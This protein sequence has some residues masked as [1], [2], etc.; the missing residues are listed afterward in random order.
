MLPSPIGWRLCN[1]AS[2]LTTI[3]PEPSFPPGKGIRE[4]T[5]P[6][7]SRR[8]YDLNSANVTHALSD[9]ESSLQ[10]EIPGA[11]LTEAGMYGFTRT[12]PAYR[13]RAAVVPVLV[14]EI[15]PGK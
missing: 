1:S 11:W 3:P 10:V 2:S 15:E 14:R 9:A 5:T 6:G 8:E 4:K 12:A 13:L 7:G